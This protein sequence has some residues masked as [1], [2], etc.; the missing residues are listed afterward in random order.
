MLRSLEDL[1]CIGLFWLKSRVII[2]RVLSSAYMV[3]VEVVERYLLIGSLTKRNFLKPM[4]K[5]ATMCE[6]D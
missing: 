1:I 3:R 6:V 2:F 4:M 5:E